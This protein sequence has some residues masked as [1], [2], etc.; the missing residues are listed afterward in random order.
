MSTEP[1]ESIWDNY[2]IPSEDKMDSAKKRDYA[3]RHESVLTYDKLEETFNGQGVLFEQ[4][5]KSNVHTYKQMT[6]QSFDDLLSNL[7]K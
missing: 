5:Q 3:M 1:E 6:Q 7:S 2:K 4:M